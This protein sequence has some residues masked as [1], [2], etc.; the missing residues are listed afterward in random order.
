MVQPRKESLKLQ[1]NTFTMNRKAPEWRYNEKTG[2]FEY[3]D[4]SMR[5]LHYLR[6]KLRHCDP[7]ENKQNYIKQGLEDVGLSGNMGKTGDSKTGE[8]T[9]KHKKTSDS[10]IEDAKEVMLRNKLEKGAKR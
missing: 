3:A 2:E 4:E 8:I 5:K 1:K 6:G 10:Q 9:E 7:L